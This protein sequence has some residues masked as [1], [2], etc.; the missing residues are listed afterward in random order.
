MNIEL[1]YA[2]QFSTQNMSRIEREHAVE[3][4][5]QAVVHEFQPRYPTLSVKWNF[6]DLESGS[7]LFEQLDDLIRR[8]AIFAADLSEKNPNVMFEFGVARGLAAHKPKAFI[9]LC[10]DK[11]SLKDLP[12]DFA[13][14][15]VE[16]YNEENFQRVFTHQLKRALE[17]HLK[18]LDGADKGAIGLTSIWKY[19]GHEDIDIVCSEI[20]AHLLPSFACSDDRNYLCYAKFADLD[21][22]IHLKVSLTKLFPNI[23]LRDFTARDHKN[24]D[25]R[26]LIVIGGP[27]WNLRSKALQDFLPISFISKGEEEDDTLII[28]KSYGIDHKEIGPIVN[29]SGKVLKDVS[30][31]ARLT[32]VSERTIFLFAGCLTFGVLGA[33]KS[34]LGSHVGMRNSRYVEKKFEGDDFVLVF[35]SEYL[36]HETFAP[37]LEVERPIASFRR[38]LNSRGDF[39]LIENNTSDYGL[40][41]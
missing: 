40:S 35:Y 27:A 20:P 28:R 33:V 17:A 19:R 5:V 3:K 6:F 16:K 15:F 34:L 29:E 38:A 8:S 11:V 37:I 1:F 22:L 24:S 7:M 31:V 9:V 10:H 26:G 4:A 18:K 14:L 36:E 25:Y 32:D 12:S 41:V 30:V 2:Y 39:S 21:S 23:G 13:G